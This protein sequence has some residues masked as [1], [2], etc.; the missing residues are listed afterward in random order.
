MSAHYRT[1]GIVLGTRDSGEADRVF[2]VFTRDFG[3]FDVWGISAR[4]IRSKLRSNMK[5][6]ACVELEFV[7][8]KSKKTLTDTFSCFPHPLLR[9]NLGKLRIA[10]RMAETFRALVRGEEQ[11]KTLW[12]LLEG[13]FVELDALE[14]SAPLSLYYFSFFWRLVSALGYRPS[15]QHAVAGKSSLLRTVSALALYPFRDA[16]RMVSCNLPLQKAELRALTKDT[17]HALT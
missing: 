12:V 7:Q 9:K 2:T 3:K 15:A 16:L 5:L 4:S 13:S 17:M 8:G 11:D 1:R 10:L 6:F 14:D